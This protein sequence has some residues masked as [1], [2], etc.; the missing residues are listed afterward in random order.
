MAAPI[1]T[2]ICG[3][4][5]RHMDHDKYPWR[6]PKDL[7]TVLVEVRPV[8]TSL[9]VVA[10][11]GG[12]SEPEIVAAEQRLSRPFPDDVR[13]FYGAM[14]P[15]ELFTAGE[16]KEFGFYTIG[17]KELMWKSM[18]GAEPA[19]DW[20]GARGLFIGQSAFGDPF[21]LAEGHRNAPQGTVFVLDHDGGL[22]GEIIFVQF[23]RSFREFLLK[24]AHFKNLYSTPDDELF[25][26]EYV[27][28]N[29][30]VKL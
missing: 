26:R 17:S 10:E 15:T 24:V 13:A 20:V 25:R 9:G 27:E 28:L 1:D 8:L 4:K 14:R 11:S 5:A 18:E 16:R 2:T 30:S 19:E 7:V 23:A 6:A 12:C 3:R 22:G 21:W 29:P